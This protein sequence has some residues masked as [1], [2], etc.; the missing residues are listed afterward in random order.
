[1][2]YALDPKGSNDFH[3]I[4]FYLHESFHY[5]QR[6]IANWEKT[7]GDTIS[8]KFNTMVLDSMAQVDN[9]QYIYL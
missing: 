3:K 7:A 6:D 1:M 4:D 8:I 9:P 5:Y 2:I